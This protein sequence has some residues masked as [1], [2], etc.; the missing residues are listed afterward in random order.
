MPIKNEKGQSKFGMLFWFSLGMTFLMFSMALANDQGWKKI[1]FFSAGL[2]F[3]IST[4][5]IFSRK[6]L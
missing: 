6:E 1:V 3:I 4:I 2:I 5:I